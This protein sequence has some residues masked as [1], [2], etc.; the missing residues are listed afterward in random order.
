MNFIDLSNYHRLYAF[1]DYQ[2]M[3]AALPYMRSVVLAKRLDEVEEAEA[4]RVVIR[5]SGEGYRNYLAP[6]YH[7]APRYAAIDSLISA[8]QMLYKRNGYSARY[9]VVERK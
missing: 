2:S 9:V 4:R 1:S 5:K 7:V 6:L 8:L 3:K